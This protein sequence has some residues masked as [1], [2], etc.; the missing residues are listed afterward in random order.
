MINYLHKKLRKEHQQA[1][2]NFINNNVWARLAPSKIHGIGVFAIRNIPKN[3][4]LKMKGLLYEDPEDTEINKEDFLKIRP[5]IRKIILDRW[6]M[7]KDYLAIKN[8]NN[9]ADLQSFMNHSNNANSNGYYTLQNIKKGE[10]ITENYKNIIGHHDSSNQ[11]TQNHLKK[12][13]KI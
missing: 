12:F 13:I 5:E 6:F 7:E 10:E 2:I 11:L 9:D 1:N 3:T 4:Y 8:P